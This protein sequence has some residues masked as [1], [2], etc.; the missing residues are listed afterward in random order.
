MYSKVTSLSLLLVFY[1]LVETLN[2]QAEDAEEYQ[3]LVEQKE[4]AA[5]RVEL[6]DGDKAKASATPAIFNGRDQKN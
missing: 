4:K 3:F 2:R 1:G 6:V 5:E